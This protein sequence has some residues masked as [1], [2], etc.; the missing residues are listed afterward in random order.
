MYRHRF[1]V[2]PGTL[3]LMMLA[4]PLVA[5]GEQGV[6]SWLRPIELPVFAEVQYLF[7]LCNGGWSDQAFQGYWPTM[8]AERLLSPTSN[9]PS[10]ISRM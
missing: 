8:R 1:A 4:M 3:I 6:Y 2:L 5:L 10:I 7:P 9:T